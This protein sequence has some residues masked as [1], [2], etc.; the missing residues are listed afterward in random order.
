IAGTRPKL[1]MIL[2]GMLTLAL[3]AKDRPFWAGG[4]SMLSCL[5]W[6]P[7]LL[8]TGTAVLIFSRY[9]TRWRDRRALKVMIGAL[10]PLAAV[11]IYFLWVGALGDFWNWTV[12]Y[13]FSVY[14]PTE[15]KPLPDALSHFWMIIR[16][17][18]EAD[19]VLVVVSALGM[20]VYLVDSVRARS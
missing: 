17:T 18:F 13:N 10:I 6:Q 5:C 14:G 7:G 15:A 3:I 9:L 1:A 11:V 20:V 16:Q 19:L 2:F 4:C 8:F 12:A